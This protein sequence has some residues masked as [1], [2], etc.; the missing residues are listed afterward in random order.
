MQ[1]G[2]IAL[3]IGAPLTWTGW[4]HWRLR[5]QETISVLEAAI[6]R[7][8]GQDTLPRTR[9]DR[10][11]GRVQAVLGLVLGPFFLLA[12]LAVLVA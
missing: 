12:G 8:T 5:D 6:L 11:F 1:A 10:V 2:F 7:T 3:A 9:F 4:R